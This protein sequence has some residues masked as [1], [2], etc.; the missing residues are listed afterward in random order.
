[1]V[2]STPVKSLQEQQ[3][4]PR[5][6]VVR[7]HWDR[8]EAARFRQ[9]GLTQEQI[10]AVIGRIAEHRMAEYNAGYSAGFNDGCAWEAKRP[11]RDAAREAWARQKDGG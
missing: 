9:L 11:E 3:E 4:P 8:E 2:A 6:A 10:G 1:M 7:S 5:T